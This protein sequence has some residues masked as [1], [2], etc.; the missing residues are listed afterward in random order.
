VSG[1]L[2][3]DLIAS[4]RLLTNVSRRS[5]STFS[6]TFFCSLPC[7]FSWHRDGEDVAAQSYP[8]S[9]PGSSERTV[10]RPSALNY[11]I[12]WISSESARFTVLLW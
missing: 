9:P 5:F 4:D 7:Y 12:K 2:P 6:G 11:E 1:S 8:K 10:S 3:W